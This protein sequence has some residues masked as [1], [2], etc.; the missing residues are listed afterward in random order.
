MRTKTTAFTL[1]ASLVVGA[2]SLGVAPAAFAQADDEMP[3]IPRDVPNI[4]YNQIDVK[5]DTGPILSSVNR[6]GVAYSEVVSVRDASWLRLF[7]SEV[8][9]GSNGEGERAVVRI[10]SLLDGH[11][12]TL[13]FEAMQKWNDSSAYFNGDALLVEVIQPAGA[14]AS[15]LVVADAEVGEPDPDMGRSICGSTDDRMLSDDPRVGRVMPIGCTAWLVNDCNKC[16]ITAGHCGP[17]STAVIQFNVPLSTPG[18]TPVAPP[19]EDQYPVDPASIQTNNGGG[20]GN[21]W[22]YFGVFPNSTT[23][24]TA[25]EAQGEVA[26][27]LAETQSNTTEIRITGFGSTTSPVDPTWYL[28]QKTHVGPFVGLFG[29]ALEYRPDTTGGN[30]GSPVIDEANG[31]ALGVH[32][33]G[34]CFSSGGEN[35]GTSI[36]LSAFSAALAAPTGICAGP[37]PLSPTADPAPSYLASGVNSFAFEINAACGT[38]P[39]ATSARLIIDTG[40]GAEVIPMTATGPNA[41]A[42]DTPP[43]TCGESVSYSFAIDNLDG[44]TYTIPSSGSF[45]RVV[46]DSIDSVADYDFETSVGFADASSSGLST[47]FWERAIPSGGGDRQDPPTDFDGS[48][49]CWVT[50]DGGSDDVD[51]GPAVLVS[52]AFDVTQISAP[53]LKFALWIGTNNAGDDAITIDVSSDDGAS[54][55]NVETT[56]DPTNGWE[57]RTIDLQAFVPLTDQVRFRITATDSPNDSILELGLD[58]FR[59]EAVACVDTPCV[60]DA[61]GDRLVN[62]DDLLVVLGAFGARVS[63]GPAEGDMNEDTQVNA[64]DLL[65]VLGAFGTGC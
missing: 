55:V 57:E 59:I 6:S 51:G 25:Y 2:G 65:L 46:V 61:N 34:G 50:E 48:G 58:A 23:N 26:F 54:W 21:D 47:G 24:L 29:T 33:H 43:L 14:T 38:N 44:S 42:V 30:S 19:P 53:Q 35:K 7:F 12:Q 10:T 31:T 15:R 11:Q 64:D 36:T 27:E 49:Y 40:S 45:S 32:T 17:S 39:D 1:T 41:V 13:D 22:A 60:G 28:A 3:A 5:L 18:G 16:L 8:E 63:G 62:A 52:P 20:V 9:L 4:V 56:F 37:L